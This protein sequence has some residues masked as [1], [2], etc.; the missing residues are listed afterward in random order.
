MGRHHG[1]ISAT[2][3]AAL[4]MATGMAHSP[5][6]IAMVAVLAGGAGLMPDLD[7]PDASPAR[8]FGPIGRLGAK[9][10]GTGAGGHRK[11]THNLWALIGIAVLAWFLWYSP[12]GR[13]IFTGAILCMAIWTIAP[14]S[15]LT[16]M[17]RHLISWGAGAALGYWFYAHNISHTVFLLAICWG[18]AAHLLADTLTRGGVRWAWPFGPR[19]TVPLAG[20]TGTAREAMVA[21]MIIIISLVFIVVMA[22]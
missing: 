1:L 12:M 17:W 14:S 6:H 20:T 11:G 15:F 13:A 10:I 3:G 4:A 9:A 8:A 16:K 22:R 5:E 2:S 18:Y 7:H 19:I 21:W